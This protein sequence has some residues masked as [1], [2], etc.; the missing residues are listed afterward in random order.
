MSTWWKAVD[1]DS[2]LRQYQGDPFEASEAVTLFANILTRL[3]RSAFIEGAYQVSEML[4]KGDPLVLTAEPNS[5]IDEWDVFVST[6]SG[7]KLQKLGYL[8]PY[9]ARKIRT[10]K[11]SA[12]VYE[13]FNMGDHSFKNHGLRILLRYISE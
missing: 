5:K 10:E 6:Q 12:E 2:L 9:L 1:F 8:D 13:P 4:Q 7:K 11:W 3:H